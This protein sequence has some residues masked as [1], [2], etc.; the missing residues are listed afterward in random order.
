MSDTTLA[1]Q[2]ELYTDGGILSNDPS[3]LGT[4]VAVGKSRLFWTDPG[5]GNTIRFSQTIE[6]GYGV[7]CPP[8]L[9]VK[10][11]PRGGP[12]TALVVRDDGAVAAF[13]AGGIYLFG[14]DGPLPNGDSATSG[15]SVPVPV[16]SPVGCSNPQ[17]IVETPVGFM[18]QAGSQGIWV[19]DRAGTVQYIGA[20]VE[21]YN[22]QRVTRA[23]VMPD[24]TQVVFLTDAGSTLLYDYLFGQWS[25]F[26]N[27][28]GLDGAVVGGSY[29]YLRTDGKVYR[30]TVGAY[31]DAGI[32]IRLRLETAWIHMAEHLQGF[33]R[34]W[35]MLLIGT[36]TSAHQ[37]GIQYTTDYETEWT[38]SYWLDATG[39]SSSTG[40]I[41]GTN[42]NTIG[43]DPIS[44]STY[45]EGLYGA[46]VYGGDGPDVYQWRLTLDEQGQSIRFRFEDFERAG[47]AGPSFELTEMLLTGGMIGPAR[48]PFTAARSK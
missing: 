41:T 19:L 5:D 4:A 39:E 47:L 36:W 27:H 13:K 2:E 40:W 23:S 22:A 32:R 20:P 29:Y 7:E 38:D 16:A 46:G 18:F 45:G 6:D 35:E 25:T 31:T 15:F 43:E 42:A 12:V 11:N 24:R 26:S 8:D 30:E 28:E 3:A 1:L 37:L 17:S 14:G 33:Q 34:F 9:I 44:G 10:V 21:A 48:K